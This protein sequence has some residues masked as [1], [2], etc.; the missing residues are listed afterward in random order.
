MIRAPH[1][2]QR[3]GSRR[4]DG[5]LLD[6]LWV[7]LADTADPGEKRPLDDDAVLAG[8]F[9]AHLAGFLLLEMGP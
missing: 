3:T 1:P 5:A 4:P 6:R 2:F 8:M 9:N 7:L